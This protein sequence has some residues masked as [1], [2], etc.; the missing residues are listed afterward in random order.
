MRTKDVNTAIGRLVAQAQDL[1]SQHVEEMARTILRRNRKSVE[2]FCLG[3]G[4]AAFY[5][6][7]GYPMDD[8]DPKFREFYEFVGEWDSTLHITG[9]PMKFTA[10]GPK[11]TDW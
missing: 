3:M 2:W 10:D 1:A 4:T 5:D 11:I 9:E 8:D 7:Q 6:M